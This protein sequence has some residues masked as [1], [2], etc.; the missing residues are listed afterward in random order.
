MKG[1]PTKK[2]Q[3]KPNE[4]KI[5]F[6]ANQ[7]GHFR[8]MEPVA[9]ALLSLGCQVEWCFGHSIKTDITDRSVVEFN[10]RHRLPP[11]RRM[12][13]SRHIWRP[14]SRFFR[15]VLGYRV[16]LTPGW[17]NARYKEI[18]QR[19]VKG[20]ARLLIKMPLME[21]FL[22]SPRMYDLLRYILKIIPDN[23]AVVSDIKNI[24]PSMVFVTSNLPWEAQELEYLKAAMHLGIPSVVQVASWDNLTTKST[25]NVIPDAIL[26]W[27]N[28]LKEEAEVLHGFPAEKIVVTGAATFDYI[29]SFEKKTEKQQFYTKAGLDGDSPY[30]V[31]LGS[32]KSIAGD[33]TAFARE[34]VR[35]VK[36]RLNVQVLIRP[37]PINYKSWENFHESGAV[38]WPRQGELPDTQDTKQDFLETLYYCAAVAGVNT[39]ALIET[40]IL[41]KPCISIKT[42]Q[43][44]VAQSETGHFRHLS[45]GQFLEIA[46]NIDEAIEQIRAVLDGKDQLYEARKAFVENFIRPNGVEIPVGKFVADKTLSMLD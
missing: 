1:K 5:L 12:P 24:Q 11:Y 40:A 8:H 36:E 19:N 33:E 42:E 35:E 21:G 20:L 6:V 15:S 3:V 16:Y 18:Y 37:H 17:T 29:F 28:S 31:Y 34:F 7:F 30:V 46:Q 38:V 23:P 41:N 43:F 22:K 2:C 14:I 32:S 10:T 45:K 25:L 4:M 13:V 39:S 26:L 27:N 9:E 44:K